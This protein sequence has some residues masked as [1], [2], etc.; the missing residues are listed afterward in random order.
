[1]ANRVIR[2]WTAS[3]SV[4]ELSVKAEVFFTRLIMKADDYGNYTGNPRLIN[5]ALF[6]LKMYEVSDVI[7]WVD[8]CESAGLLFRFTNKGKKYLHIP[9][10]G[11]SLRRMKAVFPSPT[12]D[13]SLR[14][15]DGQVTDNVGQVT[16]ETK[17]NE[18][19]DETETETETKATADETPPVIVWPS[20]D[21]FWEL[22]DKKQDR[23]KCE[24]KWKKIKQAARE[25]IMEHLELY[26]R[27]TPDPQYRKNPSTYLMNESWNNEIIIPKPNGSTDK[28][29]QG[30]DSLK[31]TFATQI[32]GDNRG[33]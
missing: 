7:K 26:V 32:V 24:K 16:A 4:D 6:P 5:A 21:D 8:E 11:Q 14:T 3:E 31:A 22:Y 23:P 29:Q 12:D 28:R 1:M 18:T 2:D 25:K 19:E 33:K 10:F 15:S 27:S 17:G 30:I 20:F 13:G 9:N